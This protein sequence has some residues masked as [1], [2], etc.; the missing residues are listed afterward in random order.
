MSH[1]T[2][3]QKLILKTA[4]AAV[5]AWNS[6]PNNEDTADFISNELS[7]PATPAFTVWKTSVSISEI[8]DAISATELVG[9][10]TGKLQQ[11]QTIS[12][13]SGG[14]IN[15]SKADRR[16]AFDQVFS[17]ASG[18]ITRPALLALWKRQATA[19]EKIFAVGV[20]TDLSPA[21]L[22]IEGTVD[23]QD[24]FAARAL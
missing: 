20:G 21:L 24:V 18:T 22:V 12:D 7:K 3:A 11:L 17:A 10:T 23:R 8:G 1:L 4:I 5:P 15:P 13:Y 2:L 14:T 16:N 19:G 6:L 9:L